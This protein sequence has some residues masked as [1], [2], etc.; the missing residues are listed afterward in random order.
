LTREARLAQ[1]LVELAD[2]LVD[3]FDVVDLMSLLVERSVELL[4][5]AAA[6]LVLADSRGTLRLMA[7]TSE[8]ME[9]VELFQV[10]NDQ[11]PCFDCYHSGQ[12]VIAEDLSVAAGRWPRFA[13]FAIHAG[14]FAAHALPMRLRRQV[15]GALNLFRTEPG[16]LDESDINAGK[17]LADLATIA[18]LQAREA[19]DTHTVVDQLQHALQNRILI[20][21]AKG[22]LAERAGIGMDAAFTRLRAYARNRQLKLAR[23]A[24]DVIGG[25]LD[26]E[27]L[28][29][30]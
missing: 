17:A 1:T 8:A 10:Q 7:S 19:H 16:T 20:E 22:V 28:V 25:R 4:D 23:V 5:A 30:R 18:I 6:G 14:F 2:T 15:I 12:P 27:E 11:G 21:Q 29:A 3:D 13:P 26:T 9:L 24:E